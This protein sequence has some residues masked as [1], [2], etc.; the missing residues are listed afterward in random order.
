MAR[1]STKMARVLG[2]RA[3]RTRSGSG[4]T[5]RTRTPMRP[6][7]WPKSP[8]VW[9]KS[10]L[11]ATTSSPWRRRAERAAKVAAWPLDKTTA[12]SAPSRALSLSSRAL[13]MGSFCLA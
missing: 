13:V 11:A 12:W 4:S 5:Y 9:P 7:T 3:S 2:L 6:R 8:M 1:V 10:P